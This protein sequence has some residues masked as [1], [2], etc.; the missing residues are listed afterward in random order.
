MNAAPGSQWRSYMD[1]KLMIAL[2]QL[3]VR[4][5]ATDE[6]RACLLAG[7]EEAA[8]KGA[9]II[10]APELAISGYAFA[11]REEIAPRV[12]T[13]RGKTVTGLAA[14]AKR[15]GVYIGTGLAETERRTGIFYN[16]AVVL[17]P[18]GK[19]VAC[20]RKHV[21]ERRWSCPGTPSPKS[22]F[23]TPWGKAGLLVC[24]DSYYGLLSRGMALHGV[25]L[26]LV[27]ANWPLAGV[28]PRE[29]WR[30]RALE[31]G[32]GVI[33]VNRTGIDKRMDCRTAPS[34][35]LAPEG[36]VLL[37]AVAPK[38]AIHWVA[39]PLEEG[40]FPSRL[41]LARMAARRPR[42][43]DAIALDASGLDD[44]TGLWG[45]P[46]PASL[47]L[48]C[49]VPPASGGPLVDLIESEA[50]SIAEPALL[51]CPS[52]L[53]PFHR[54]ELVGLTKETKLALVTHAVCPT[55]PS[56]PAF[57]CD[58]QV[59]PL[60]PE[61]NS[62][63]ADFGPARVALVRSEALCHPEQAVAL[64]KQGC[65][66]AVVLAEQLDD[67]S[68]LLM[69]VKS[70]E[71]MVVAVAAPDGATICEPPE[72]HERWRE[73]LRREPGACTVVIDTAMTRKKRFLERVDLGVLL[74][75]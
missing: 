19:L 61:A 25:D 12:E 43:Y 44:F 56:V 59:T 15:Y 10:M 69:G 52:A 57:C 48:K 33:A 74:K 13:V 4:H 24:A 46:A 36:R 63:L 68:R 30:A 28:D 16:S 6:N 72:T 1:E 55:G 21:A 38:T 26:L 54:A 32:V 35:A 47:T 71:K 50:A 49:L 75:R 66:I 7:A 23:S 9:Q 40:H 2:L 18:D 5:G 67:D 45:L 42:D 64:S 11:G 73:T 62:V 51:L 31:N 37:D 14:I 65:D 53:K 27:C 22:I 34:Y 20:H 70:L 58:G 29:I 41:R 60:P 17:G 8:A 3:A 39:Y